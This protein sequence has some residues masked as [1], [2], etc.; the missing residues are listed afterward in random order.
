MGNSKQQ[1]SEIISTGCY[2]NILSTASTC[3]KKWNGNK[4]GVWNMKILKWIYAEIQYTFE[5][6]RSKQGHESLEFSLNL[7]K[8]WAN[9]YQFNVKRHVIAVENAFLH[10]ISY[11]IGQLMFLRFLLVLPRNDRLSWTIPYWSDIERTAVSR[12]EQ[13]TSRYYAFFAPPLSLRD[14]THAEQIHAI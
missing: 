6:N 8:E 12:Y 10:W 5:I 1:N 7:V 14:N 3:G 2:N 9:F 13:W 4:S 11:S